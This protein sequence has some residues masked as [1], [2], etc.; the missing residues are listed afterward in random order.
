MANFSNY[1]ESGILNWLFRTNTNNYARPLNLSF[2]L[3]TNVPVKTS[4][5]ASC[6]EL[7]NAN[8]YARVNLGAPANA[9]FTDITVNGPGGSGY[10]SNVS[11]ISFPA[12]TADWGMVSGIAVVD[13]GTYGTGNII[14]YAAL[15]TPRDVKNGKRNV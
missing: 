4:T 11:A 10:I 14:V 13:S 8:G 2:A 1:A 5:G 9:L 12:A 6:Y 15:A 3:C 7:P